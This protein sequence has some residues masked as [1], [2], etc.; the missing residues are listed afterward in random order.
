MDE[1]RTGN[2]HENDQ[3]MP[4]RAHSCLASSRHRH[5]SFPWHCFGHRDHVRRDLQSCVIPV[6]KLGSRRRSGVPGCY[7]SLRSTPETDGLSTNDAARRRRTRSKTNSR[8]RSGRH[9][10]CYHAPRTKRLKHSMR[11]IE[12]GPGA[13]RVYGSSAT[14]PGTRSS[15]R[16][17]SAGFPR[18]RTSLT[19]YSDLNGHSSEHYS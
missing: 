5:L 15:T 13:N 12:S 7:S 17:F 9:A 4:S 8:N 3:V 19:G 2:S 11:R 16:L 14:M 1:A 18:R 10:R 6:Q